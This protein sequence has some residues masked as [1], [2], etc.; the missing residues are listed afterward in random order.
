MQQFARAAARL[1]AVYRFDGWL[2]NIE[3][4]IRPV[5]MPNLVGLVKCLN[6]ECKLVNSSAKLIWYDAVTYPSGTLSW[7]DELNDKNRIFF[8]HCDGIFLNYC[9]RTRHLINSLSVAGQRKEDVYVGIDVFGGYEFFFVRDNSRL[10]V[11]VLT[12][13][14][15]T[16]RGCYASGFKTRM[17]VEFVRKFQL[18]IA[19]FAPAWIHEVIQRDSKTEFHENNARFWNSLRLPVRHLPTELPIESF[20]C[21]GFGRKFFE[22]GECVQQANWTNQLMQEP[23]ANCEL[24]RIDCAD[25]LLGGSCL[26]LSDLSEPILRLRVKWTGQLF[27]LLVFKHKTSDTSLQTHRSLLVLGHGANSIALGRAVSLRLFFDPIDFNLIALQ[28][29]QLE[30]LLTAALHSVLLV[31]SNE[32]TV[33]GSMI[34]PNRFWRT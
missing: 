6:E 3:N 33:R 5:L 27:V 15:S 14:S 24:Q 8:D 32:R 2:L 19:L 16:G 31:I 18:S 11:I 17:A 25:A 22:F 9:W 12:D 4:S 26:L 1:M 7:Q 13:R 30:Q 10:K 23:Q 20:F 28:D 29:S 34:R 21:Q